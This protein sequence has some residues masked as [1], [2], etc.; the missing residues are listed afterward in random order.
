MNGGHS[1]GSPCLKISNECLELLGAAAKVSIET[2]VLLVPV[3]RQSRVTSIARVDYGGRIAPSSAGRIK[4]QSQFTIARWILKNWIL[5]HHPQ[6]YST[7][8]RS[9]RLEVLIYPI[10]KQEF[11][12]PI[13]AIN[14]CWSNMFIDYRSARDD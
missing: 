3:C 13:S 2:N 1:L 14:A 9:K 10:L 7:P 11:F 4:K 6:R 8:N 5:T 12:F